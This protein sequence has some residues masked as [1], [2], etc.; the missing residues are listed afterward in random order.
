MKIVTKQATHTVI[1]FGAVLILTG[2]LAF[3]LTNVTALRPYG[4]IVLFVFMAG[5]I[6]GIANS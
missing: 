2:A 6:G 3:L 4:S 1:V 5:T